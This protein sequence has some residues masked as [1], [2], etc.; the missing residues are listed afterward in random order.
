MRIKQEA[1]AKGNLAIRISGEI[2]LSVEAGK[3][4]QKWRNIFKIPQRRLAQEMKVMPSVISDYE[5]GRRKSP[6]IKIIKRIVD[7]LIIIDEKAGGKVIRE[8][9]SFPSETILS[10]AVLDMREF[11]SPVRIKD[12][13]RII[14]A[15]IIARPDLAESNLYGYTVIDSLKA[16]IDL[17][18]MELVKLYGL[19]TERVL[20]FTDIHTGKSPMV[21][22]KV[23]NLRPGL[24]VYHGT[25]PN[26]VDEVAKRIAEV[27][28]IPLAVSKISNIE[29]LIRDLRKGLK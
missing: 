9:S 21:A 18:P 20:I 24:V 26:A 1:L 8:F 29:E 28:A 19:T 27:E 22:I 10:D 15:T 11:T 14:N 5:S 4:I 25:T 6:G 16:V 3:T 12:F 17:P 2:V 13:C 7:A 23:T